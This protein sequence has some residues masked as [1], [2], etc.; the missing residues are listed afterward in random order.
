[1]SVGGRG[2]KVLHLGGSG[3]FGLPAARRLAASETVTEICLAG[4]NEDA[5]GRAVAQVGDKA[6]GVQLDARDADRVSSVAADFDLVV[7]TAGPEWEVLLP[8]LRG[9]I[10]AGTHYCDIGAFGRT[11]REQLALDPA[12]KNRDVVAVLGIGF[13]PGLDNLLAAYASRKLDSVD[14]IQ[15]R[16]RWLGPEYVS[17]SLDLYRKDGHVDTSLQGTLKVLNE[18]VPVYRDGEWTEVDALET[19]SEFV[20]PGARS[21]RAFPFGTS[22][23]ITLPRHVAGV[24]SVSTVLI[25]EPPQLAELLVRTVRR[26]RTERLAPLGAAKSFLGTVGE[27]PDR[28]LKTPEGVAPASGWYTSAAATGW[29][30]GVRA[31]L[32]CWPDGLP[33]STV[34]PLTVAALRILRG[35]VSARGVLPPEGCFEPMSFFKETATYAKEEDRAKP[36]LGESTEWIE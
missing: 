29:K 12:A 28:W 1:M 27:D 20:L 16:H 2:L 35:E 21:A 25:V 15:L 22:E 30:E 31:R 18:P 32:T 19:A 5:L 13:D 7:N 24:R 10:A 17:Q 26:I 6:R 4:R 3:L 23:A 11:A 34:I 14:E 33:S 8:S 9:A 36:L